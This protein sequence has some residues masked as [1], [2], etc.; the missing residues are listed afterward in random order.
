MK[1]RGPAL[2][3]ELVMRSLEDIEQF[4][5]GYDDE[6]DGAGAQ[7]S[8]GGGATNARTSNDIVKTYIRA[9]D[10]EA[11]N[12]SKTPG[13]RTVKLESYKRTVLP[14]IMEEDNESQSAASNSHY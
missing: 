12:E 11:G 2:L 14:N 4:R 6:Q 5:A 9:Q 8:Q 13:R 3:S 10:Q 1:S 7:S